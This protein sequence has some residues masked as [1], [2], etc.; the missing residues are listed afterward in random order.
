[1]KRSRLKNKANETVYK[2]HRNLFIKLKKEAKKQITENATNK[3]KKFWKLCKPFVNEKGFHYKQKFTKTKRGVISS[4]TTIENIF[5]NYFLNI[6]KS[7]NAPAQ[8][9]ENSR[10]NT[11]LEKILEAFESH[12][13]V[14][15][16]KGVTFDTKF[17]FQYVLL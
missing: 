8:N 7:L 6:A 4:K 14:R 2:K 3:A 16:I 10:N 17:S 1:M 5:N 11:D 13:S 12:P 15:H 9:P